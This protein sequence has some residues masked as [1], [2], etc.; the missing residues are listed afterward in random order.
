MLSLM[1]KKIANISRC[2]GLIPG[3]VDFVH[4]PGFAFR[5]ADIGDAIIVAKDH[6]QARKIFKRLA[7]ASDGTDIDFDALESMS[8]E[9]VSELAVCDKEA[10]TIIKPRTNR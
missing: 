5:F 2:R 9:Y 7:I 8:N 3:T 6:R 4:G 1:I 10:V